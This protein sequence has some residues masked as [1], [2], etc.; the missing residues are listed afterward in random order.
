M[1]LRN[2]TQSKLLNA[3]KITGR[4]P[5]G[6]GIGILNAVVGNT[7]A[8]VADSLG[9][10]SK[11][12]TEPFSNYNIIV[13]DQQLKYGSDVYLINTNV[14][15]KKYYNGANVTGGGIRL[16]N[17]K[18]TYGVQGDFAISDLLSNNDTLKNVAKDSLGYK[19]HL[20][21]GK[22][23]GKFQFAY[24]LDAINPTY[25]NNTFGITREVNY[26]KNGAYIS[27]N[28]F[29]PFGKFLEAAENITVEE[30][31][32]FT[33]HHIDGI[34][35]NPF[36][37]ATLKSY[38][39]F[40]LGGEMDAIPR[41][42]YY[43]AR[44][45]GRIFV[46]TPHYITFLGF[47]SD[48]RKKF[49]FSI[50]G[51]IGTTALV[52]PTIGYNTFWGI[53]VTP[54]L[55]VSDKLSFELSTELAKDNGDRG[56]VDVDEYGTIIFGKRY[57]TDLTNSI[58]I[59]YLFK[60]NLSLSLR[61]RHYWARGAYKS[62]YDLADDG[63]LIDNISYTTNHDFNFNAFNIDMLF[64]WQF[65]PGSSMQLIYKNSIYNQ[66]DFV[67]NSYSDNFKNTIQSKQLNTISL[68]VLYY[69]DYLYLVK[70]QNK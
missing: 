33:T 5:G 56:Y 1:V 27:V 3:T 57:L 21:A 26:Y 2:P 39:N 24:Y 17:K 6:L 18:S 67:I 9:N 7:Y 35:I 64:Q 22:I 37:N 42:D 49:N 30:V 19:Y 11:I 52:S 61:G 59:K 50:S 47:N 20:F 13:L 60:N 69:F 62:F 31:E 8:T 70:K 46:R 4:T 32:N 68:K 38:H 65:A 12:L 51:H 14:D 10:K 54:R 48:A 25:N 55:R 29:K 43:E 36:L 28:Q 44:T 23:S 15:R 40:Y 58:S 53:G 16:N 63:H 66:G 34:S 41:T 45:P